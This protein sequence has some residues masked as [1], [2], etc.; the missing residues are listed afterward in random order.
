MPISDGYETCKN[1]VKLYN[2]SDKMFKNVTKKSS[3]VHV[4]SESLEKNIDEAENAQS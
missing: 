3:L 1:V 2:Y 4:R